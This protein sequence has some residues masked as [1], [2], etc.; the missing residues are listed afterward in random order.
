[1]LTQRH[2]LST[3]VLSPVAC[4]SMVNDIENNQFF[5]NEAFSLLQ[6]DSSQRLASARLTVNDASKVNLKR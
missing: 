1:M 5:T 3:E 2:S 6:P 4:S